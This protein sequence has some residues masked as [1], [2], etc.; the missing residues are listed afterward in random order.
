V[1]DGTPFGQ[2]TIGPTGEDRCLITGATGFIGGRLAERLAG[3]G[4]RLRCLVR[5]SSDT[6]KLRD[7]GV[8]IAVG[9]LA[10]G[11]SLAEAATGCRHVFHCAALVSDWA[12]T[13]EINR[14]NVLG[15]R[16]L[17]EA[18]I[19]ASVERF[20]HFSTTDVYGHP[21]T[22]SVK[23]D[24]RADRF[25]NWYA[26]TKL[27]AE[28]EVRDAESAGGLEAVILR[29][30]TVYGPG[31]KEV[32]GEIARAIQAHHMLLIDGGRAVAGL[33]YVENLIDAAELALSH[34]AAPG[35]AF[36][37][38][39]GVAV[40]WRELA[41]DLATGL[42]S[43]RV[44]WSLPYRLASG[45]AVFLE[46]SYRLLRRATGISSPPLLS[47]QAVQ[48]LGRDQDFSNRKLRELLGWEP[49]VDYATGLRETVAWLL[50][51][52]LSAA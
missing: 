36:N 25:R 2:R 50:D 23:E 22:A 21:A 8:E 20:I 28:A 29:P 45:L 37:V 1:S 46:H 7:L 33:C 10:D 15:T 18:S 4:H 51:A 30:A 43:P 49:R 17:L 47:R 12:T 40:T 35:Q 38:S 39:D 6:A 48:V 5:A 27:K 31:S 24:H 26:E 3:E 19:A 42:G 11:R 41:D 32:I 13:E 52:H 9:D 16:N 44:R 14:A 34:H